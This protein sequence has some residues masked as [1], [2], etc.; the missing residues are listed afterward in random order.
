MWMKNGGNDNPTH[1]NSRNKTK[2][3]MEEQDVT[4]FPIVDTHTHL[5]NPQRFRMHWIEGNAVLNQ[6]YELPDYNNHTSDVEIEAMVYMEVVVEP[7]YRLLEAQWANAQ[8]ER[9]SRLRGIV[10]AAPLEDGEP[11][12]THLAALKSIGSRIKGVRRVLENEQDDRFCLRPDF[13]HGVQML[14]EFDFSFDIC[15]YH[16]QLPS[17]IELVQQCPMINFILDHIAKPDIKNGKFEPWG[18]NMRELALLP[19]VSCKVSGM[20]TEANHEQWTMA[21]LRP[22]VEHVI[23][24]FGED[25]VIFGGDW[26][27][28]LMASSYKRWVET[29][30]EIIDGLS[31]SAKRKFWAANAKRIYQL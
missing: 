21:D 10:A 15:I 31:D 2:E 26:P 27:V 11:V 24:C 25:R 12:R 18:V 29:L 3:G 22:Y 5:W 19:N 14:K 1:A 16:Y 23:E 4:A 13:V 28:V 9:E 8:A 17:V 6:P 7:T 30:D 20:V